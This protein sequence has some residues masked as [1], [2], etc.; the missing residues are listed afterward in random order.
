[1]FLRLFFGALDTSGIDAGCDPTRLSD[2]QALIAF[3][4]SS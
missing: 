3:V 1:M 4:F 2:A